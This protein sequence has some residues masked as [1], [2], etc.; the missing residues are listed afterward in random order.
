MKI[1][2]L[3]GILSILLQKEMATAPELARIFEVSR[4]TIN[5][6]IDALC[7]AG[8]PLMTRQ[9]QNGGISIMNGYRIDRTLLTSSELQSI[10][11][12][13][14]SL[15]SVAGTS[16]YQQLMRK[17]SVGEP[18]VEAADSHICINLSSWRKSSLS[19][20]IEL[21]REAIDACHLIQFRYYA[22]GGETKRRMEPYLLVFQWSSWYVWGYCL[23]RQD[24]RMFK[25]NRMQEL[26]RL[27]E[28]FLRREVPC[29]DPAAA[30]P[31]P[32][33]FE[34]VAVCSPELK[35]RLIEEYGIESF[36]ERPDGSLLFRA[37]F[38]D[39]EHLF[40]WVLSMGSQIEL[41]KPEEYRKE[42]KELIEE[43]YKKYNRKKE[44]D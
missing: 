36:E 14:K 3:I 39:K 35:W 43:I 33:R 19:P 15:D 2:R 30:E 16:R 29:F 5:R 42:L 17:L 38:S 7:R 25:L 11:T 44:E 23:E 40:G 31:F 21:I 28:V 10:L 4:R 6:D 20:K 34:A 32:S 24:Y 13:L 9:G 1:D 18:S 8:I 22:P 37:G 26:K 41:L 27:E 12:G